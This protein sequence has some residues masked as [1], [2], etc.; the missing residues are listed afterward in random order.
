MVVR[1]KTPLS[2]DTVRR[3][4]IKDH[5]LIDGLVITMRD[6]VHKYLYES[7]IEIPELNGGIIYHSGPL[8]KDNIVLS[9]GPTTSA[10]VELYEPFIIEN[11]KIRAIIGKGGMGMKTLEAMK[12]VGTV[13][14][15]AI[16][17]AGAFLAKRI[18]EIREVRFLEEF[19]MAEAMWFFVVEEFPCLVTMDSHGGDLHREIKDL[20]FERFKGITLI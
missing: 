1:L 4:R 2:E 14:L 5:V 20:S 19:G 18:K 17:G 7:K 15:S 9:A 8:I 6:R 16:G 13:Y 12:E 3:L 11:Y 10:R